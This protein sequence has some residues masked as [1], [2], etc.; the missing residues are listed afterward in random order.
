MH[1]WMAVV[2]ALAPATSAW[3]SLWSGPCRWS[4]RAY[5]RPPLEIAALS[6]PLVGVF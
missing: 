5:A 6:S 3:S 1:D 4:R 2:H